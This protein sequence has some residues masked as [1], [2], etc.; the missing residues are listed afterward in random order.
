MSLYRLCE[1]CSYINTSSARKEDTMLQRSCTF[2][3]FIR[4]L[5]RYHTDQLCIYQIGLTRRH[6]SI[7]IMPK[8]GTRY[9]IHT[10]SNSQRVF[11]NK[12]MDVHEHRWWIYPRRFSSDTKAKKDKVEKKLNEESQRIIELEEEKLGKL[13]E[14]VLNIEPISSTDEKET[15]KAEANNSEKQPVDSK[16][17]SEDDSISKKGNIYIFKKRYSNREKEC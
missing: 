15:A 2:V 16:V 11:S 13:K 5:S 3:S 17:P 10:L 7:L 4:N 12:K 9:K 14:R 8:Y 6:A 1:A